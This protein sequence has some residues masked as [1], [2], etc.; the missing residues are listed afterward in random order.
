MKIRVMLGQVIATVEG[1]EKRYYQ[2]KSEISARCCF[3]VEPTHNQEG[4]D[5]NPSP[6]T[7][8]FKGSAVE[9]NRFFVSQDFDDLGKDVFRH[10]L[11][12]YSL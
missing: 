9:A 1:T 3:G 11:M 12:R 4:T 6:A 5:S 2:L 10:V 7:K 8:D